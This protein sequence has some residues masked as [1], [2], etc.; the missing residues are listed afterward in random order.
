[1]LISKAHDAIWTFVVLDV[2]VGDHVALEVWA[3]F[4]G[5]AAIGF[6]ACMIPGLS[7]G[8]SVVTIVMG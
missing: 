2:G 3:S 7:V 6:F 4:E 8:L 5:F 1:M